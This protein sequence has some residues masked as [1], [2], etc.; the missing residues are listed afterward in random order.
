M[1]DAIKR[2]KG[3]SA[4]KAFVCTLC[5]HL[6]HMAGCVKPTSKTGKPSYKSKPILTDV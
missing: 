6:L 4:Y 3:I 5:F 1:N 2:L